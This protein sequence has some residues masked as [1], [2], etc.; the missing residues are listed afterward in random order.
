MDEAPR[1]YTVHVDVAQGTEQELGAAW[2]WEQ[3]AVGVE[4]RDGSTL[5]A[6]E[7]DGRVTLIGYFEEADVARHAARSAP[8]A[9][10]ARLL[11]HVGD[12]WREAWKAWFRP[13]RL[14]RRLQVCPPWAALRP[15]PRE[16]QVV[17]EPGTAF[18]SGMHET[19][20]LALRELDRWLQDGMAVLDVGCGSGILSIAAAK[21]GARPVTGIDVDPEAVRVAERNA[22]DNGV[23]SCCEFSARPLEALSGRW[24]LVLANIQL[25]H[26]APLAPALATRLAPGGRLVV[27]G[28]LRDELPEARR[29]FEAQGAQGGPLRLRHVTAE[30]VWAC[31]L[32]Q[33]PR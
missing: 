14:G 8:G 11:E 6:A 12:G 33:A 4:E 24:P 28:V 20:R 2:L 32:L 31:L 18:G 29:L 10:R 22:R 13:A 23:A 16:A 19:T 15:L 26:L 30:G 5:L 9:W 7:A 3:G 17:I 25:E 1:H 21:L 27:G